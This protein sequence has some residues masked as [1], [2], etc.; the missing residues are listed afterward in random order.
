MSY[1]DRGSKMIIAL[2]LCLSLTKAKQLEDFFFF[3]M[4]FFVH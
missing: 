1:T 4:P 2:V 3:L